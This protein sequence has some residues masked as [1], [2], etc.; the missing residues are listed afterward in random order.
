[1]STAIN[2]KI[3]QCSRCSGNTEYV[4]KSCP[5]DLCRQCTE[6]HMHDLTTIDHDVVIYRDTLNNIPNQNSCVR[7]FNIGY[8]LYC[9]NCKSPACSICLEHIEHSLLDVRTKYKSKQKRLKEIIHIIK[10][11][12]FFQRSALMTKI[13]SDFKTFN[14]VVDHCKSDILCTAMKLKDIIDYVTY[15]FM[16]NVFCDIDTEHRCLKQ[17]IK[18]IKHLARIQSYENMH[19]QSA[20]KP[21][22]FLWSKNKHPR[23]MTLKNH[24]SKLSMSQTINKE[25][26]TQLLTQIELKQWG[27]RLVENE[28]LLKLMPSPEFH[29]S[30]T[31]TGVDCCHHMSPVTPDLFWVSYNYKL[32]LTDVTGETFHCRKDL[33]KKLFIIYGSHTVNKDGDLFFIDRESD[34]IKLSKDMKTMKIFI[35]WN[36]STWRPYCVYFSAFTGDLLVGVYDIKSKRGEVNRYNKTGQNTRQPFKY[37]YLDFIPHYITE[38]SNGDVV[39]SDDSLIVATDRR[40]CH[41]STTQ[42]IHQNQDYRH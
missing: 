32:L 5:C 10:S 23:T 13:N 8:G 7:H 24:T 30:L 25:M 38:N 36:Y 33:Y 12:T 2:Y 16:N 18:M 19:V 11:T 6:N 4:C 34:I 29:Q 39:V 27:K 42:D 1:M 3:R 15:D 21:I 37:E 20:M 17:K 26:V 31:V 41:V 28:D 40:E 9:K 22:Q 35:K 14:N